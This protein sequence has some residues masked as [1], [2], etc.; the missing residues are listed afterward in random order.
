[1]TPRT[2]VAFWSG[3]TGSMKCGAATVLS[4]PGEKRSTY[5]ACSGRGPAPLSPWQPEEAR[6]RGQQSDTACGAYD[7]LYES[8]HG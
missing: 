4:E 2:A 1:M 7:S 8:E 5:A 3:T 6:C